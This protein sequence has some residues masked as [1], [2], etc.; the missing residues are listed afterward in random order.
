MAVVT[1]NRYDGTW[2]Q[3]DKESVVA[4]DMETAVRV[5]SANKGSDPI[6]LQRVQEGIQVEM[7]LLDVIFESHIS[8][9]AAIAAGCK[10]FPERYIVPEGTKQVFTCE[11]VTGWQLDKW[12]INGVDVTAEDGIT[13]VT[14][15][16]TLL[17]IPSSPTVVQITAVVSTI[18]P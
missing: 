4:P 13:L 18:T 8:D 2:T 16:V 1:L 14:N 7:P 12:Q 9:A 6:L 10:V 15:P 17:T 3:S 5:L 11:L